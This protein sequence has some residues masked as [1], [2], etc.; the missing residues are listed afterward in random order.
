MA[1]KLT[2]QEFD[3]KVAVMRENNERLK[4][5]HEIREERA[6]YSNKEEKKQH[7][8]SN[9]VLGCSIIAIVLYTVVS[10]IIQYNTGVEMSST[11]STLWYGFWT[12]EITALAGIKVTKVIKENNS[13]STNDYEND[14]NIVG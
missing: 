9:I 14:E 12:V 8:T 2:R 5:L 7:K 1:Q 10:M 3:E 13:D 4:I 6:K 11:L